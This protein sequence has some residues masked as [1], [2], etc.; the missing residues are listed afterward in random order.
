MPT[1]VEGIPVEDDDQVSGAL[2]KAPAEDDNQAGTEENP[3]GEA[4]NSAA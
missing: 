4:D 1:Y 3:T 2:E